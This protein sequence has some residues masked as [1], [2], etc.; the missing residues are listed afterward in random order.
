[1]DGVTSAQSDAVMLGVVGIGAG[2]ALILLVVA[3]LLGRRKPARLWQW[4]A[5]LVIQ[6]VPAAF[7]TVP[8]VITVTQGYPIWM[9]VGVL[10]LW[11]LIGLTVMR[12]RWAAWA[13]AGSAAAMPALVWAGSQ[14]VE[15][16]PG[17]P[18][19]PLM[20]LGFYSLRS[21]VSAGLLWWAGQS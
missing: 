5:A 17:L 8:A 12:P 14:W 11:L 18:I 9:T 6:A 20:V 13:L 16:F 3:V 4:I 2:C 7:L 15:A 1:M 10:G 21:V 19:D